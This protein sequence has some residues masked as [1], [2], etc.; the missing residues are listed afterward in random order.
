MISI[1]GVTLW[2]GQSND[3]GPS[4]AQ[5][6]RK[7]S[8]FVIHN[9]YNP[10]NYVNCHNIRKYKANIFFNIWWVLFY[11]FNQANDIALIRMN[12]PVPFSRSVG[13]VCLPAAST[14]PDQHANSEAAIMGWGPESRLTLYDKIFNV[15]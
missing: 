4:V 11:W 10:S 8:Q 6:T 1:S 3:K 7:I 15:M 9:G 13:P 12:S 5:M 2:I 14:D